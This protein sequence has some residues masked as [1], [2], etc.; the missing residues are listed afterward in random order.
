MKS[1]VR[2]ALCLS[3]F[4]LAS[5]DSLRDR[6]D[7]EASNDGPLLLKSPQPPLKHIAE[8]IKTPPVTG[9]VAIRIIPATDP[10]VLA[11]LSPL[12]WVRAADAIHSPVCGAYFKLAF[13]DTK[14][15]QLNVDT[16]RLHYPSPN[17][18]PI[19]AWT[20]NNGPVQTHQ[21]KAGEDSIGLFS[22]LVDRDE[23]PVS[24]SAATPGPVA[25][26]AIRRWPAS[27]TK[28]PAPPPA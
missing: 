6:P 11:G 8:G 27:S 7:K 1:L 10:R 9:S 25:A 14:Y 16:N 28:S 13:I 22:S 23:K 5:A 17:R 12:N 2:L 3:F 21:L 15:V 4:D 20:V 24:H 26:E 18:L 19:V